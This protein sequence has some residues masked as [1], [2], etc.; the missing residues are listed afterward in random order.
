[1][2]P[3]N[4]FWPKRYT[5]VLLTFMALVIGYT[6]RVNISIA[7]IQMQQELG[8]SDATKGIVL[9]SFFVGYLLFQIVGGWL[10]N[11]YG[12]RIVLGVAVVLWSGFTLLTPVA[13]ATGSMVLLLA[14][15]ILLGAGEASSSPAAFGVF[16]RWIPEGERA[17]AIAFLS[18]GA[19]VGTL[20]ALLITGQIIVD[21]GWP[22]AFYSFGIVGFIW[23]IFWFWLVKDSPNEDPRIADEEREL[24]S[25]IQPDKKNKQP[26]PWAQIFSHRACWALIVTNFCT[27]WGLYV[28]LAWLPSYFNDAQ[29]ISLVGSGLYSMAPWI[30]MFLAMNIAGVLAD[31]ALKSGVGATR[32][33]KIAQSV[34]LGGSALFLFFA[35]GAATPLIAVTTMCGALACLGVCYAG[36]A[37]AALEMA[38]KHS[39]VLWSISNTFGTIPG[40]IGIA[41]TGWLVGVTGTYVAAFALAAVIHL[42]GMLAW[43]FFGTAK[44]V[45]Y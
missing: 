24:L 13:A 22:M 36:F 35:G 39:D 45:I 20:L 5:V 42:I 21:Y 23:A 1:M 33:R 19:I 6:D 28:A 2:F 32:V 41:V 38:P 25:S 17:R 14:A 15:R 44:Q 4:T 3:L 12:G 30:S 8:W 37:P 40:I 31:R 10:S 11:R 9:S 7:A 26:V 34:G 18:S 29:G 27:N 43:L 16:S